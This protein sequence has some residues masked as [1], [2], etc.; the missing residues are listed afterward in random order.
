MQAYAKGNIMDI[1]QYMLSTPFGVLS[2]ITIVMVIVIA[3]F[4][5]FWVKKQADRDSRNSSE[6]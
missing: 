3:A 6:H 5:F 4:L 1:F 2:L